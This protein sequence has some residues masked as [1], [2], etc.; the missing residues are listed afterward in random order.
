[1]KTSIEIDRSNPE[2]IFHH[3][4]NHL[5]LHNSSHL[6]QILIAVMHKIVTV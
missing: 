3:K 2:V 5:F 4:I 1:M 6:T